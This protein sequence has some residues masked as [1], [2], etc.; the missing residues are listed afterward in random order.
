MSVGARVRARSR[1]RSSPRPARSVTA[2]SSP[3]SAIPRNSAR[4]PRSPSPR[5]RGRATRRRRVTE[6]AGGMLNSVGL[7]GPGVD[8]WIAHDLPALETRGA[9]V[10]ASIWGRSVDDYAAVAAVVE[11]CRR[12]CRRA[13]GQL[14][15]SE[16]R[17][18][19]RRVR[20]LGRSDARGDHGR[21]RHGAGLAARV[22]EALA[23]RHRHRRHRACGGGRRRGRVSRSS[24]P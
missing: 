18:A 14:V 24:T 13:R 22:R 7:P 19:S 5:I 12:S 11:G 20:A 15:V 16:R 4:S 6:T 3:S 21:R 1:T 2:T 23:E 9:R 17:S 10:I 8:A